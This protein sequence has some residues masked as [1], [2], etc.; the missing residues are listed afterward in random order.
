MTGADSPGDGRFIHAGYAFDN[1]AVRRNGVASF[2]HN[3]VAYLQFRRG[4][5]LLTAIAQASCHCVLS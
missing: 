2:A 4:N 5:L 1:V 3:F